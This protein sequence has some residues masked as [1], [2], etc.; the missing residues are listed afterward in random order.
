MEVVETDKAKR[1]QITG[2]SF[3]VAKCVVCTFAPVR[4]AE[5]VQKT[6]AFE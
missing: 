6:Q 2:T 4:C 3:A 5:N 1:I